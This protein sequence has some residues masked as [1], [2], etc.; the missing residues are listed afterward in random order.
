MSNHDAEK[1]ILSVQRATML[2][3]PFF[4]LTAV[5]VI[6]LFTYLARMEKEGMLEKGEFKNYQEFLKATEG[7]YQ[8]INIPAEKNYA[9]WSVQEV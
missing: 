9:P 8:I 5:G 1:I 4:K 6:F 2:M 7:K 3:D